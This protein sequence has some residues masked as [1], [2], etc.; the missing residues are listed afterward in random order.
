MS[1]QSTEDLFR[2]YYCSNEEFAGESIFL[3]REEL[4]KRGFFKYIEERDVEEQS[5]S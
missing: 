3:A 4:E 2:I 1:H 5:D